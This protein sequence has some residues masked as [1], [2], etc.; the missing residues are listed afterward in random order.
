ML[1]NPGFEQGKTVWTTSSVK[2]YSQI[3]TQ[4]SCGSAKPPRTGSYLAWL[5]G[6]N[7]ETAEVRQNVVLPAGQSAYLSYWY[8]ISSTDYCNYDYAYVRITANGATKTLATH[9]L[10]AAKKTATWVK[11]RI[12]ISSYAGK[13]VTITFRVK[14]DA[15][16]VSSFFVDDTAIMNSATCA[17]AAE[18]AGAAEAPIELPAELPADDLTPSNEP[19]PSDPAGA[20]ENSR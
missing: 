1:A 17:T 16:L 8:Q 9:S 11:Q 15:S 4:T 10:C 13:T 3:C 14:N 5:G 2:G 19:K 12:D 18:A 6:G 20:E 7:G